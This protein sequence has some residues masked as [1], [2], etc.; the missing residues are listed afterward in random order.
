VLLAEN[1][2][3]VAS[4]QS[5][6]TLKSAQLDQV[7]ALAGRLPQVEAELAQV[8]RNYEVLHKNHDQ[9]LARRESAL[10]GVKVDESKQLAEFRVTEPPNLAPTPVFP[11]RKH[12][13]AAAMLL[14]LLGGMAAA[15]VLELRQPTVNDRQALQQ[16]SGRPVL[17]SVARCRSEASRRR[18]RRELRR[19]AGAAALLLVCQGAWLA[20]VVAR[21]AG[22]A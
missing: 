21:Q 3:Q 19:F 17:G 11:A 16:L 6:L 4:L 13:A 18:V 20:W 22:A 1:E 8:T 2:A 14:A 10:L 7:R 5:Q 15:L 12:L 9:L